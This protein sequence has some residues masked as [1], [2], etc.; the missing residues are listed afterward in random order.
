MSARQ[1][2]IIIDVIDLGP[3][4]SIHRLHEETLENLSSWEGSISASYPILVR[5][6][7]SVARTKTLS[8]TIC[9]ELEPGEKKR[10]YNILLVSSRLNQHDD[11]EPLLG[12]QCILDALQ[13][14][15]DFDSTNVKLE[16]SRP[17]TWAAFE[18]HLT[19]RSDQWVQI[20]GKGPWFDLV[21]FDVHGILENNNAYL[22]FQSRNLNKNLAKSAQQV[23]KLLQQHGITSSVLTSCESAKVT[24]SS[25]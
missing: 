5:R 22:I 1:E 21:H 11:I 2:Y 17:G 4:S 13:T 3:S 24:G 14:I 16:V 23:A 6:K 18:S 12:G 10:T 9:P 8:P 15:N 19:R 7:A 25:K 20:G